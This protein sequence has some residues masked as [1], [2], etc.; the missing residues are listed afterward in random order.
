MPNITDTANDLVDNFYRNPHKIAELAEEECGSRPD[1]ETVRKAI[2]IFG[3]G[4]AESTQRNRLCEYITGDN[5]HT[6]P[7]CT[8]LRKAFNAAFHDLACCIAW[9]MQDHGEWFP[10]ELAQFQPQ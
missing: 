2:R 9:P 7:S 6:A 10:A 3:R 8:A 4:V 1:L 5:Y